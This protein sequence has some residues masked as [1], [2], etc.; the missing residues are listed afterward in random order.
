VPIL[1]V[2]LTSSLSP[3]KGDQFTYQVLVASSK[4]TSNL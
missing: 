2:V 1:V 4:A 3:S